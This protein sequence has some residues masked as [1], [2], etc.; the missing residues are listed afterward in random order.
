MPAAHTANGHHRRRMPRQRRH[1]PALRVSQRAH[2]RA[3]LV[4]NGLHTLIVWS[5][6][7]ATRKRRLLEKASSE[8]PAAHGSKDKWPTGS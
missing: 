7:A 3:C 2:R 6:E 4:V 8:M 5:S 1:E